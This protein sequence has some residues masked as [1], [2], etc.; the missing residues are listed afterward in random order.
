[1]MSEQGLGWKMFC[2]FIAVA[3]SVGVMGHEHT[4]FWCLLVRGVQRRLQ[5]QALLTFMYLMPGCLDVWNNYL[6]HSP[7]GH[8]GKSCVPHHQFVRWSYENLLSSV[9]SL[10]D[11]LQTRT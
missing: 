1:M 11:V 2:N 8:P 5:P 10:W 7:E 6:A 4:V 3:T 9:A